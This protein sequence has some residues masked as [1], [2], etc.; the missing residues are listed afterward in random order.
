MY[1]FKLV[2]IPVRGTCYY[3][4]SLMIRNKG[5][6]VETNTAPNIENKREIEKCLSS[7]EN[8]DKILEKI[9]PVAYKITKHN[10]NKWRTYLMSYLRTGSTISGLVIFV[11]GINRFGCIRVNKS[12]S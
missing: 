10:H 5:V 9:D 3:C 8:L 1:Q 2:I 11:S 6:G 7:G 4:Y 12:F